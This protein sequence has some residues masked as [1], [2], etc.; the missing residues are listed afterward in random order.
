ML[1]RLKISQ[2]NLQSAQ[3]MTGSP[4]ALTAWAPAATSCSGPVLARP[5]ALA[6][7][8]WQPLGPGPPLH[9][10]HLSWKQCKKYRCSGPWLW[11]SA[12]REG[13]S[14]RRRPDGSQLDPWGLGSRNCRLRFVWPPASPDN[15]SLPG[16]PWGALLQPAEGAGASPD[17]GMTE[18]QPLEEQIC[19]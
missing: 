19:P 12:C 5:R 14:A 10:W 2:S 4:P 8:L 6:Q 15:A 7:V 13:H 3:T 9:P 11:K 1:S 16:E 17:P 18:V